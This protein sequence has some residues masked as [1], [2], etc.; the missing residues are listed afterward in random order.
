VHADPLRAKG[1]EAPPPGGATAERPQ[2]GDA[3]GQERAVR[4]RACGAPLASERD[5]MPLEGAATRSYVN[6]AGL[7]YE[8]AAFQRAAGCRVEGD[9][10]TFWTWFPGHAWQLALCG[11][12]GAHVGWAFSGPSAFFGLLVERIE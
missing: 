11:R 7:V 6:P 4:C 1:K 2:G 12:C 8:V 5:R 3:T 9:P 10:S